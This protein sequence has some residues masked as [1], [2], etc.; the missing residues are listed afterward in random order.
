M[1]YTP[2][3]EP[4]YE[5]GWKN[6]P[7]ETTPIQASALNA[8]DDAIENIEDYL[9]SDDSQSNIA[10]PYSDE[11]TYSE[12]DYRIHG[13][14]LY[15]ANQDIDT[16]EEFDPTKWDA[17]IVT[18]E[19]ATS[20]VVANPSGTATDTL[21]KIEID[22][23][24]YGISGGGGNANIWTGTQEEL[25]EVFDE[26]EDGTQINITDDEQE[27]VEG[28]TIYSTD[29]QVIGLWTD[30]RP[31][32]QKTVTGT[33]ASSF[34]TASILVDLGSGYQ[35]VDFEGTIDSTRDLNSRIDDNNRAYTW[36]TANGYQ[37]ANYAIGSNYASK[38][39]L[40]TV[41]Y[42]KSTDSPL[43]IVVGK[44]TMYIASSDCYSTVEKEVGCWQ[45][46]K[47][48]YQKTYI[49]T[50]GWS[51]GNWS[52]L[53]DLSSLNI[54]TFV[55]SE[56]NV[57][58]SANIQITLNGSIYPESST[59]TAYKISIRYNNGN[60]ECMVLTYNDLVSMTVTITYTK[61]TDTAGSGTYTP[62]SGKA[63]HYSTDEQVIGTWIDGS[64]LYQKTIDLG[65]DTNIAH[66]Q[67]TT[68]GKSITGIANIIEC[69][70]VNS[71]GT[72]YPLMAYHASGSSEIQLL[73]CRDGANASSR[74]VTIK[75]TKS[76]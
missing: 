71:G 47:P 64:T 13:G 70:S 36:I 2:Q 39:T 24:I 73:A 3:F 59:T 18:D 53:A 4:A 51:L 69:S 56:A 61:S 68:T 54:D 25:E 65:S 21:N 5:G 23:V 57:K 55:N 76:A 37:I 74:Y 7:Y 46:G 43:D 62:A 10:E 33:S 40:V 35:I 45:D 9:A 27:V 29:E 72:Y 32:Y 34:S 50:S 22:D 12:G 75:Y 30:N 58:R 26:L 8:Y 16:A 48:L 31:L 14:T 28:G 60:L 38:D 63:I 42:T 44:S 1:S 17:C 52:V 15:K 6:K 20:G 49:F 11:S 19:M 41:K 66:N 67:W